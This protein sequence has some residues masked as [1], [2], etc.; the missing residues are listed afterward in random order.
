MS[1]G[2]AILNEKVIIT[3][4]KKD[5]CFISCSF[6]SALCIMGVGENKKYIQGISKAGLVEKAFQERKS[7]TYFIMIAMSSP[8]NFERWL[9]LIRSIEARSGNKCSGRAIYCVSPYQ[10]I[11]IRNN[12]I[13]LQRTAH[14][15]F[16]CYTLWN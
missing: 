10:N 8:Y 3:E 1:L 16:D 15:Q 2:G 11:N 5:F 9:S 4:M 13:D 7:V 12:Y 6:Y 14:L